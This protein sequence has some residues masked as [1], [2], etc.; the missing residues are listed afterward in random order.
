MIIV[1]STALQA[2]HVGF[3]GFM[4]FHEFYSFCIPSVFCTQQSFIFLKH[5][6]QKPQK[7]IILH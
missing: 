4:D 3:I 5:Y 7:N 6:V 1:D 2:E